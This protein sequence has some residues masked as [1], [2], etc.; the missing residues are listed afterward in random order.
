MVVVLNT[1]NLPPGRSN[2][3]PLFFWRFLLDTCDRFQNR[4]QKNYARDRALGGSPLEDVDLVR[5]ARR[6]ENTIL[7]LN[8]IVL[9]VA[10]LAAV[11]AFCYNRIGQV[12]P[13]VVFFHDPHDLVP[14]RAL[15][16]RPLGVQRSVRHGTLHHAH[17]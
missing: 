6:I 3:A 9:V 11:K 10:H 4:G 14:P 1:T 7:L 2:R 8:I 12:V 17:Q 5:E 13:Q 15:H 16:D